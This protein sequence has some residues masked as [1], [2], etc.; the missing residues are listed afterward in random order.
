MKLSNIIQNTILSI[1]TLFV[2]ASSVRL[3][4]HIAVT[5][6]FG[7]PQ[8]LAFGLIFGFIGFLYSLIIGIVVNEWKSSMA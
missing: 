2:I 5:E 4:I 3:L 7:L 1:V 6:Q 8:F